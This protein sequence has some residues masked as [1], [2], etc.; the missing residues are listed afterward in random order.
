ML[1]HT[2]KI[3]RCRQAAAVWYKFDTVFSRLQRRVDIKLGQLNS[4]VST[5]DWFLPWLHITIYKEERKRRYCSWLRMLSLVWVSVCVCFYWLQI[6]IGT[7][8]FGWVRR[9]IRERERARQR[10]LSLSMHIVF[11]WFCYC[12]TVLWSQYKCGECALWSSQAHNCFCLLLFS[13]FCQC[14]FAHI[15]PLSL[16]PFSIYLSL[17]VYL[18]FFTAYYIQ[19]RFVWI[20]MSTAPVHPFW[21][22]IM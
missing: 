6:H 9:S 17:F 22:F 10:M 18:P 7:S 12:W 15:L 2:I 20:W 1:C 5:H 11:E 3:H 13:H 21:Q 8:T 4:L 14:S 19:L 16:F